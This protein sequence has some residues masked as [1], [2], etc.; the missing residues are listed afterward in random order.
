MFRRAHGNLAAE[1]AQDT[2]P[3][4]VAGVIPAASGELSA[5]LLLGRASFLRAELRDG[6]LNADDAAWGRWRGADGGAGVP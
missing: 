3:E 2:H 4:R 1:G 5:I 6:K